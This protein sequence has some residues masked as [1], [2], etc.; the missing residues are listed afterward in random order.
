MDLDFNRDG[1]REGAG[2]PELRRASSLPALAWVVVDGA[3]ACPWGGGAE[4]YAV[5]RQRL[6]VTGNRVPAT[7]MRSAI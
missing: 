2:E 7:T 3:E 6:A 1:D 5:L 4:G